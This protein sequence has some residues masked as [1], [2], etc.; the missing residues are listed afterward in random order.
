M[1]SFA[2]IAAVHAPQYKDFINQMLQNVYAAKE[3]VKFTQGLPKLFIYSKNDTTIPFSQGQ[4]FFK[5]AS[6][7]KLFLENKAEHIQGLKDEPKEILKAID[8][9]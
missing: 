3:D 2:D 4:E 1:S 6:E 7:P 9:L 8:N 5:N